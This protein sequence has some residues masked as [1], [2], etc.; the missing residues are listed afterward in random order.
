MQ[1]KVDSLVES[2]VNT[3][4]GFL[5][6]LIVQ[7]FVIAPLFSLPTSKT[8]DFLI[9]TIFTVLSVIRSYYCRRY[10]NYRII[11]NTLHKPKNKAR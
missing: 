2:C 10:F 6:A 9:T 8:Q 7:M 1:S 3:L 5:V 4:I 11:S